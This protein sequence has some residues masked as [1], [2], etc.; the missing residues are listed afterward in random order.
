MSVT[1]TRYD[2]ANIDE[3]RN[4]NW[5]EVLPRVL[6][7][8]VARSKK[9]YWLGNSSVNPEDLV[10]EAVARALGVGKDDAYRN[11]NKDKYP[12]F[13]NFLISIIDSMTNHEAE[14][15]CKFKGESFFY[16][17]G[18]EKINNQTES[19]THGKSI[20]CSLD[21]SHSNQFDPE[22][23]LIMKENYDSLIMKVK[24][25]ASGD[26]EM[27]MILMC[28]EYEISKPAEISAQTGFDIENVY[29]L[30]RRLRSKLADIKPIAFVK[31]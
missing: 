28:I 15:A 2:H 25:V 26:D 10:N 11:W 17:D 27:G 7:Y 8:A 24:D 1:S 5:L 19:N 16:D 14:H 12:D 9:Y 21:G 6:K 20:D 4:Q 22:E 18:T 23:M 29:K 31:E 13:V 30:L 3:I